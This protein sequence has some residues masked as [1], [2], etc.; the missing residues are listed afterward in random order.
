MKECNSYGSALIRIALL[1]IT[2]CWA[3]I[4]ALID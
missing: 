4:T 3:E 1:N 2:A